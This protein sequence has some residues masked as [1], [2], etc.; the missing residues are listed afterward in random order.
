MHIVQISPGAGSRF[1]CENCARDDSLIRG[2]RARGHTVTPGSLY[3]PPTGVPSADPPP[4]FYGA[5][6][7][8]LRHRFPALRHAPP[9]ISR[10]FDSETLLHLAG[11]MSG[12][13]EAGGLEALTLSMLRGEEGGQ[14]QELDH[15]VRWLS[16]VRPQVVHLSN[17][18][19]LGIARRVRRELGI[20]VVCSLQDEDTWIDSLSQEGRNAAWGL[21]R[22]RAEDVELFLPVSRYYCAFMAERL[23]RPAEGFTVVPI[24]IDPQGFPSAEGELP[25]DP[26]TIGFLSHLSRSMGADILAEAF[27]LL[28]EEGRWP[29]LRLRFTGG[30][31]G[32]DAVFLRS[33]RRSLAR[34][35]LHD[36][37]DFVAS[38]DR[39]ARLRFLSS[40][41]V[42]S[43]P[44]RHGE[45]FG[46]FIL[47]ALA[48]GVPVVQ[49]D[50]GGF[51]ELL[52]ATGGGLLYRPNTPAAL[53]AAL[54][55][56]LSQR[57]RA[58]QLGRKGRR[59]V[60]SGYTAAHMAARLEEAFEGVATAA[61]GRTRAAGPPRPSGT[62]GDAAAGASQ[63][64][65]GA[66]G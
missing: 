17:C 64:T 5:V 29:G 62:T 52:E 58:H 41:S 8:Y 42:L 2:L 27:M 39:A 59:A 34:A 53:A 21:L 51:P 48:A 23:K 12:T 50:L 47:E 19:L 9:W 22:E 20:P 16:Q 10:L 45:A 66:A 11:G 31:T 54:A 46:T 36:R 65:G 49:P 43:V 30:S 44:V 18:L 57:E 24:G 6:G 55:E 56:L 26:P 7:L 32:A 61:A 35:G 37:V 25:W 40:L 4:L 3:L 13:T 15:L 1:Y 38:F 60:L 33:V 14:A 63:G 28:C